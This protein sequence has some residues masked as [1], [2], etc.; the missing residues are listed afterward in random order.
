MSVTATARE[1]ITG[2]LARSVYD[3]PVVTKAFR[4]RMRGWKAYVIMG[5]YVALMATVL[6]IA[7]AAVTAMSSSSYQQITGNQIV[8]GQ[9]LFG[10]LTWAQT[11]LLALIIPALTSGALTLEL[12]KRTMDMLALTPLSAGQIV[13]GKQFSDFLYVLILLTCSLPLAGICLML[14]GI[15]PLEIA[16]TYMLLV[17]WVFLLTCSGVLWS[18]LAKKTS[19][20]SGNNFG[21][22]LLYL[23]TTSSAGSIFAAASMMMGAR[24]SASPYILLNPGMAPWASL[25]SATVCGIKVSVALVAMILNATYGALLLMVAMT[26][27]RYKAA[28]KALP[29]RLLIL[30]TA[31]FTM[32]LS[33][34]SMSLGATRQ[35]VM[36]FGM[37]MLSWTVI[38]AAVFATGVV[39]KPEKS[40]MLAYALSWRRVFKTDIGGAIGFVLLLI[41]VAYATFGLTARAVGAGGTAFAGMMS[42]TRM[43][44]APPLLSPGGPS[45]GQSY[46]QVGVFLLAMA[47][48]MSAIGVWASSVVKKRSNAAGLV[49]LFA[50]AASAGY[51]IINYNVPQTASAGVKH[52]VGLLAYLSPSTPILVACGEW[53]GA[54]AAKGAWIVTSV[55]YL[56]IGFVALLLAKP[57]LARTGGV[58]AEE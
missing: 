34:G 42:S 14:G 24:M 54:G 6:L 28:E 7:Y 35:S 18:S 57:A 23:I 29:I 39:K 12:E 9:T 11:I 53:H 1:R 49:V 22:C 45:F 41:T 25:E 30:G 48:A 27:V 47:A 21:I 33:A 38:G 13:F 5:A 46:F 55:I 2:A 56:L 31:I 36:Q 26:H 20:A 16:I 4:T 37:S 52:A 43:P 10:A 3:N 19:V 50:I 8:I 44:G 15:S 17:G 40:S 32:W 58:V 51:A